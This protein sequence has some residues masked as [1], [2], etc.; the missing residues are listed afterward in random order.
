MKLKSKIILP[1]LVILLVS[2]TSITLLNYYLAYR[3]VNSMMDNIVDASLETLEGQVDR[4][5]MIEKLISGELDKKNLALARAFGEIVRLSGEDEGFDLGNLDYF[6]RITEILDV[7]EVHVMDRNGVIVGSN[8]DF[9]YGFDF[10][11]GDQTIPFLR[12]LDEPDYELA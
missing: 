3:T 5:V 6:R 7:S 11:A 8:E 9:Y 1:V 12:I 10:H 2:I 4:A